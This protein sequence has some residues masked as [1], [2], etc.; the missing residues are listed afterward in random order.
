MP[1]YGIIAARGDTSGPHS[2]RRAEAWKPGEASLPDKLT[3][4]PQARNRESGAGR[5]LL[6]QGPA[7]GRS[8]GT[9]AKEN[10]D[11]FSGSAARPRRFRPT[12]QIR[13]LRENL[14]PQR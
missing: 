1:K 10:W 11:A 3:A 7:K 12:L 9:A 13:Q 2:Q 4:V 6:R 14:R 5:G 8:Q